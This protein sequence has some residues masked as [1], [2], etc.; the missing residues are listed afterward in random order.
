MLH[1]GCHLSSSKGFAAMGET[2][3]G[4]KADTFAFL[5]AIRVAARPRPLIP[6]MRIFSKRHGPLMG[7]FPLWPMHPIP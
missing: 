7:Q 4:I 1:I 6:R 2:A 5:L 3:R